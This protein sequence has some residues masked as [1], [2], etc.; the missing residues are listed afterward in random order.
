MTIFKKALSRRTLLRGTGAAVALPLLDAMIP[1][2]TATA[3]TPAASEQLRRIGYIYIPMG[4]NPK[5]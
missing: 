5:E 2:L 3:A 1:A 4:C